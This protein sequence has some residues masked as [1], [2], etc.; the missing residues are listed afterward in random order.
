MVWPDK[1]HTVNISANLREKK[2]SAYIIE[3][4]YY[5]VI[6]A[7]SQDILN[8]LFLLPITSNMTNVLDPKYLKFRGESLIEM[9]NWKRERV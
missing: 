6:V 8:F 5:A 7:R 3:V 4:A 2:V 9:Y 1:V